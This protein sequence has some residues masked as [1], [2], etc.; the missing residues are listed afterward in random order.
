MPNPIWC[1]PLFDNN[2]MKLNVGKCHQ[3]MFAKNR[4]K[5]SLGIGDVVISV[6]KEEKLLRV[7][8]GNKLTVKSHAT[9]LCKKANLK[10]HAFSRMSRYVDNETLRRIM[11]S[12]NL[13]LTAVP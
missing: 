7:I 3:L 10:L 13:N 11:S 6:N 2:Y 4:D 12:Y 9:A 8:I 1:T 5:L